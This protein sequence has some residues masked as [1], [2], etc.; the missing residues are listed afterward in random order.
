MATSAFIQA[1]VLPLAQ[2]Q[3]RTKAAPESIAVDHSLLGIDRERDCLF[4]RIQDELEE[5]NEVRPER[6]QRFH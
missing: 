6:K 3:Q 5:T 4:D 2:T 1:P